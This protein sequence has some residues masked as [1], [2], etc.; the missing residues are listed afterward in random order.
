MVTK[1]M[2]HDYS[3]V[4][5]YVSLEYQCCFREMVHGTRLGEI[6]WEKRKPQLCRIMEVGVLTPLMYVPIAIYVFVFEDSNLLN[7]HDICD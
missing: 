1:L 5:S 6:N 2:V 3:V 4:V 7:D